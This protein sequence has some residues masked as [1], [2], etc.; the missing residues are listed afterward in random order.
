MK[1][2]LFIFLWCFAATSAFA[3]SDFDPDAFLKK[4]TGKQILVTDLTQTLTEDQKAYLEKKLVLIDDSTSTQIAVILIPTVGSRELGD[5]ATDLGRNWGVGGAEFNNGIVL[6]IAKDDRKLWIA[7]GYGL[8]GS[9]PDATASHIIEDVIK[10]NFRGDDYF[11]GIDEG[12]DAIISA[13]QGTYNTPRE[14]ESE[15]RG[16]MIPIIVIVLIVLF[17]VSRSGGGKGGSF[18]SRRGYRGIPG[19]FIFPTGGGGGGFGGGGGG[20][21]F[22][23]FGGGGF[24]GGGAGGS[25]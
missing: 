12:T 10:P 23:G 9:L 20:G 16:S 25:W 2:I 18:M 13:V 15:G 14:R 19:P 24:G 8:E 5:Y 4:P 21:G 7:T 1:H 3:Q 17:I 6:L 22:G 11:R